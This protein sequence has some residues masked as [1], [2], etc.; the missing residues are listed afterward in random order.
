MNMTVLSMFVVF[1]QCALILGRVRVC[2]RF[3]STN[4]VDEHGTGILPHK[5]VACRIVYSL[6]MCTVVLMGYNAGSSTK[7]FVSL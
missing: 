1:C 7:A 5:W 2:W 6:F 4:T 3:Y